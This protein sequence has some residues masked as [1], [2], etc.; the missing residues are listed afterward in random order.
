M[1]LKKLHSWEIYKHCQLK[2][3]VHIGINSL[4][5]P[6]ALYKASV[7]FS[8][9]LVCADE[10]AVAQGEP[11]NCAAGGLALCAEG[12]VWSRLH[13]ARLQWHNTCC[14]HMRYFICDIFYC[15]QFFVDFGNLLWSFKAVLRYCSYEQSLVIYL[16]SE[17]LQ[18]DE[19]C[20]AE[21]CCK[22]MN[23]SN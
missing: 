4:Q 15:A 2:S 13:S 12:A 17:G 3:A 22:F 10:P 16:Q 21:L 8:W 1:Q 11:L 14:N 23:H 20:G 19:N 18:L 5:V 7:S 6:R 9:D